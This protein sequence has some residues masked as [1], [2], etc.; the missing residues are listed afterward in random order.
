MT[1]GEQITLEELEQL[2]GGLRALHRARE[3]LIAGER[4]DGADRRKDDK[5]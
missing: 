3:E 1:F 2:R 4:D 5:R